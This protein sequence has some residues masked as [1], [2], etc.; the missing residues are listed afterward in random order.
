MMKALGKYVVFLFI[1]L[2]VGRGTASAYSHRSAARQ[3]LQRR[4]EKS[5][6]ATLNDAFHRQAVIRAELNTDTKSHDGT[7]PE[8]KEEELYK[9]AFAKTYTQPCNDLYSFFNQIP[10]HLFDQVKEVLPFFT[11]WFYSSSSRYLRLRVL[12][13]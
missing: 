6:E 5:G 13:I 2:L 10:V 3:R 1:L 11:H 4:L 7:Y 12:R 8:E 9:S